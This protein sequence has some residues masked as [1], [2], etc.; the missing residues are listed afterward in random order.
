MPESLSY[1]FTS[2]DEIKRVMTINGADEYAG[3]TDNPAVIDSDDVYA[4]VI[5]QATDEVNVYCLGFYDEPTLSNNSYV[6]RLATWIACYHLTCRKG[7]QER[8][9]QQYELAVK[10]LERVRSGELQIPRAA[11]RADLA[12]CHSNYVID[13][14]FAKS[15]VRVQRETSSGPGYSQQKPDITFDPLW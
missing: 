2:E 15:K 14:R 8:Y 7:E 3:D 4:D 6:R 11:Q 1:L 12:P 10:Y 5:A 9:A 13:D